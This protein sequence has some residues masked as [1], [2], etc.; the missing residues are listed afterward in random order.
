MKRKQKLY[1]DFK[2]K[3]NK[4][5]EENDKKKRFAVVFLFDA[6]TLIEQPHYPVT[7]PLEGYTVTNFSSGQSKMWTVRVTFDRNISRQFAGCSVNFFTAGFVKTNYENICSLWT[8]G[9]VLQ[10]L[11]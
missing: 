9:E 1:S 4:E 3:L 7:L 11:T 10:S 5:M 2:L 6:W 8:W